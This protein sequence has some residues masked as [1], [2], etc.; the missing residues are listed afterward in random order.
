MFY[1]AEVID[2]KDESN[3]GKVKVRVHPI[4][5]GIQ[6]DHLPW[7]IMADSSFSSSG[8]GGANIPQIGSIVWVFFE[9]DDHRFPVMFAGSPAIA[10]NVPDIPVSAY[11]ADKA[12][13][14]TIAP[15]KK[16]G[17]PTA[18]GGSWDEPDYNP[19][20]KYPENH[21]IKTKYHLI[22]MDDTDGNS[23]V[24]IYHRSGSREE[25]LDNGDR[26]T[27]SKNTTEVVEGDSKTLVD[28]KYILTVTSDG[29]ILING[30][31]VL[32]VDGDVDIEAGGDAKIKSGG[33]TDV[34]AGGDL[35]CTA[36]NVNITGSGTVTVTGSTINLN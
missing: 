6:E 29:E 10:N 20:P 13:S 9:Q 31:L 27:H 24:H 14:D 15:N 18:S 1:R 5:D 3:S 22:E 33:N 8:V 28:G 16:T 36:S 7:A 25:I 17:V 23:R 26:V 2:N 19:T 4:H 34:E 11:D 21:V 32:K 30:N 35:T 12:V